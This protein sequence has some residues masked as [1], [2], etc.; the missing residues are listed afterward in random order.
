[1]ASASSCLET[2]LA[3]RIFGIPDKKITMATRTMHVQRFEFRSWRR[4][5]WTHIYWTNS[6]LVL[7]YFHCFKKKICPN[8]IT[9]TIAID[10]LRVLVYQC[11]LI[12]ETWAKSKHYRKRIVATVGVVAEFRVPQGILGGLGPSQVGPLALSH[13]NCTGAKIVIC[14]RNITSSFYAIVRCQAG[15]KKH[16]RS[17]CQR[18]NTIIQI[19]LV[20][21]LYLYCIEFS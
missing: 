3:P 2:Q 15:F 16:S 6:R 1:M 4:A 5:T 9:I 10:Y 8:N 11:D 20:F 7:I 18:W 13:Q 14:V 19:T 17:S 12:S 21:T